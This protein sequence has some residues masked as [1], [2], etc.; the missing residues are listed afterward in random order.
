VV[1][2]ESELIDGVTTELPGVVF[3]M[4]YAAEVTSLLVILKIFSVAP[5]IACGVLMV[6]ILASFVGRIFLARMLFAHTLYLLTA[7]G[8]G[9]TQPAFW[10]LKFMRIHTNLTEPSSSVRARRNADK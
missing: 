8:L 9:L 2:A 6:I 5:G 1:E 3:S 10:L 7:L 4:T